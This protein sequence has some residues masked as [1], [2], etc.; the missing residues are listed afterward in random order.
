M[1]VRYYTRILCPMY[2]TR[3]YKPQGKWFIKNLQDDRKTSQ[4]IIHVYSSSIALDQ[5]PSSATVVHKYDTLYQASM[6][7]LREATEKVISKELELL[8]LRKGIEELKSKKRVDFA[9]V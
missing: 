6:K 4:L 9:T 2:L 5:F 1:I 3:H 8:Q 7:S